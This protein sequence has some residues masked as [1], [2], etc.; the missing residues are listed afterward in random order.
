MSMWVQEEV[1]FWVEFR[2]GFCDA[3]SEFR[4]W[5]TEIIKYVFLFLF[6]RQLTKFL[7]LSTRKQGQ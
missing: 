7:K 1:I 6:Q 3:D 4:L 2:A 5:R